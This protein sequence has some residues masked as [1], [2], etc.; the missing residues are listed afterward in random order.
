M[1]G[2]TPRGRIS[3][4]SLTSHTWHRGVASVCVAFVIDV[5]RVAW[6]TDAWSCGC[7]LTSF[8]MRSN[9]PSTPL[10]SVGSREDSYSPPSSRSHVRLLYRHLPK[11][12]APGLGIDSRRYTARPLISALMRRS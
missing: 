11:T 9:M 4:G 2:F 12:I 6:S 5:L 3:S 7:R 10:P 1:T 8:S